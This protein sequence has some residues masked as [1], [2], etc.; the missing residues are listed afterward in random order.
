MPKNLRNP[1][2]TGFTIVELIIAMVL[3]AILTATIFARFL[4]TDTFGATV[5]QNQIISMARV[6]QQSS[7]GRSNVSLT[8]TPDGSGDTVTLE[9]EDVGGVIESAQ[10]D[11]DGVNIFSGDINKAHPV[12]SCSADDGDSAITNAAE[13]TLNFDELGDL[14]V[15]GITGSTGAVTTALRICINDSDLSSI[16]VSPSGFAYA[17][18]CDV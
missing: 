4:D 13:M 18:N 9:V 16:C 17:G 6:A 12:P 1:N 10:L 7:L 8:I 5:L 15:S 11:M 14:D 3:I 2:A